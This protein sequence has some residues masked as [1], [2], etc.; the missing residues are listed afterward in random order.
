MTEKEFLLSEIR[1]LKDQARKGE[2]LFVYPEEDYLKAALM[3]QILRKV[4][5]VEE[6]EELV[7]MIAGILTKDPSKEERKQQIDGLI[8]VLDKIEEYLTR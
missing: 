7:V 5:K 1:K 8:A 4:L 6:L 2:D 3:D